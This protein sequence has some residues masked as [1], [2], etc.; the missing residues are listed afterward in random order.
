MRTSD[1]SIKS[2]SSRVK[3]SPTINSVRRRSPNLRLTSSNSSL[4]ICA[5]RSGFARM[6]AK[7]AIKAISSSYSDWILSRSKPVK[8]R[9][10]ISRIAWLGRSDNLNLLINSTWASASVSLARM[11]RITSSMW[12]RAINKPSKMC[13]RASAFSLSNWVRRVTTS[14]WCSI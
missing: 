12:S 3:T 11:I 4:M 2:S 14:F 13:A 8:R 10:R 9:R 7:S 5:T 6:S 1:S